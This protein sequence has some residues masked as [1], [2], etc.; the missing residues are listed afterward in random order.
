M[1]EIHYMISDAAKKVDVESHVLRY[2]EEELSLPILRNEMG[3]RYY[4]NEDIQLFQN[5]KSLKDQG[6]QL[7]AIKLLLPE[8]EKKDPSTLA[9][10]F[11]LKEE[12]NSRVEEMDVHETALTVSSQLDEMTPVEQKLAQFQE[13]VGQAVRQIMEENNQHLIREMSRTV[14]KDVAED[15]NGLL[16]QREQRDEERFRMLD[17]AIREKQ[18][19]Y[20]E[21]A[22]T[23]F[24]PFKRKTKKSWF[25]KP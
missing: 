25:S 9:N 17:N 1:K 2:W 6:F 4:T 24:P 3:H 18:K 22:V 12:L 15:L 19:A 16:L 13:I 8:L 11:L 23:S 7:K 5:I 14:S 21:V 10:L 20:K